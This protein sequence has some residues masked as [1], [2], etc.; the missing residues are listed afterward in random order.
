MARG[1]MDISEKSRITIGLALIVISG[2]STFLYA[3]TNLASR[4]YVDKQVGELKQY[5]DRDSDQIRKDNEYIKKRVDEIYNVILN[6]R[7]K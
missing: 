1:A 7:R 5:Y 6:M 4:D 3:M 2:L